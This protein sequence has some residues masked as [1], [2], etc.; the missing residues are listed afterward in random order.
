MGTEAFLRKFDHGESDSEPLEAG[1]DHQAKKSA[2]EVL[3]FKTTKGGL[4]ETDQAVT[5]GGC[6]IS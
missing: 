1:P 6:P 5:V 3:R 4:E 2:A